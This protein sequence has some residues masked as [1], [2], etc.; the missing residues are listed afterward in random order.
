MNPRSFSVTDDPLWYKDAIIYEVHVK[1]FY[2]A[3]GDGIGDIAGL[4]Q[5]LDYLHDL[6]VTALWVLPFYPSPLRDDGYDIADYYKVNPT[7]GTIGDFM[8]LLDEAHRRGMRIITELVIN[9]T[10]DKH[11]WFERARRAPKDSRYR[12]YYVW[13]D[14]P[15]KYRGTRIIFQDFEPSNWSWDPVAEQYYWHRFYHHQPDL[16]FDNPEVQE[17]V[18]DVLRFWLKMGID[19]LRLDAVP[20][21]FEREGT[22]CENLPETHVFLKKLRAEL[23]THFPNRMLLAEANQWPED[24]AAYFGDGDECH[25]NFHFPLM[26]RMFMAVQTE[27]SFP[28]LDILEQT[29]AI[30]PTSQWAIFLRNHD[31]L[32]LEMVTDEDRDYMY[33]V[34]AA[35]PRARINLGIRRRLAPLMR[36]RR[37]IE[38]MNGLLFSMPGTPVLYYGDEI[39]M[40]DNIY[41]GDRDGVRTPMQWSPDRNA[42]FSRVNPQQLYL[43]VIVDPEYHF[44]TVNVE[45]QENNPGS[46]LWW[47]KRIISLRKRYRAFSRGDFTALGSPNPKVLAFVRTYDRE[48]ILIVANLSRYAQH[49]ELDLSQFAGLTPVEL[50]GESEFPAIDA[51]PYRLSVGPHQFYWFELRD[52]RAVAAESVPLVALDRW[53]QLL[54]PPRMPLLASLLLH[55]LRGRRWFRG[56]G[57]KIKGAVVVDHGALETAAGPSALVLLR[58][59]YHEQESETYFMEIGARAEQETPGERT[60]VPPSNVLTIARTESPAGE[61]AVVDPFGDPSFAKALL[62]SF[63]AE[64]PLAHSRLAGEV[65][66]TLVLDREPTYPSG[67]QTNSN[68]I[69]GDAYVLKLVRL[70]EQGESPEVEMLR[71]LE[72][73][74]FEH[75]ARLAG[76]LALY[77]PR[78][79][80]A[81]VAVLTR[82]IAHESDAWTLTLDSIGRFFERVLTEARD[83]VE[84]PI[85]RAPLLDLAGEAPNVQVSTLIGPYLS[86]VTLL[87]TRT[88]EM[89]LALSSY[90]EADPAFRPEPMS[91]LWQRGLYQ[92][93]RT[94]L[95]E[96]LRRIGRREL[97]EALPPPVR[98]RAERLVAR[99]GELDARIRRIADHRIDAVRIRIHGDYHLGQVLYTGRD[100]AILDFE[101]EPARPLNERRFKRSPMRDVAGMLRSFHYAAAHALEHAPLRDEDRQ[102]LGQWAELWHRTIAATFLRAYLERAAGSLLVPRERSHLSRLVDFYLLD[103]CLYELLY[104]IDNRPG[105][106]SIPL[107]GLEMLLAE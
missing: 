14:D 89:H 58:V 82:T 7:Y 96:T 10:S 73:R 103:K 53:H 37:K 57:R 28:I 104:E 60:S 72:A 8:R 63:S 77:G 86:L 81:T 34:Y 87:G 95:G 49:T 61:S 47:Q 42:G 46:L 67:E 66:G 56:K 31:E 105:W 30:H 45:A 33:R 44:Q 3:N 2:D 26:P 48:R 83:V 79:E 54:E 23:D 52:P 1:T 85:P 88:A 24:A 17:A 102:P 99:K 16:N 15:E 64:T 100:F 68:V 97:L 5:K 65:P 74:G 6:G 25:M 70:V 50:F 59:D 27:S 38:L 39:G 93:A 75:S 101:G 13:S 107:L 35:D 78:G 69:F 32:T 43:P 40:G 71:A 98:H 36:E 18:F 80:K 21:L 4:I 94:R 41:L 9:H 76:E 20:Y 92:S 90:E 29:P 84:V 51:S 106:L 91:E 12:N 11:P 22:N 19:G 62:A 55:Y